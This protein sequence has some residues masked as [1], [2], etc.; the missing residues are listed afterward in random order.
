MTTKD[1]VFK[2][3]SL[4]IEAAFYGS[5]KVITKVQN[6][7]ALYKRGLFSL[8]IGTITVPLILLILGVV[9]D[10]RWIIAFAGLCWAGFVFALATVASPIAILIQATSSGLRGG[11][12]KYVKQVQRVLIVGLWMSLVLY[13]IPI[14]SN[15]AMVIPLILAGV[16]LA[17]ASPW[18]FQKRVIV[19]VTSIAMLFFI[20]SFFLPSTFQVLGMEALKF[21]R[22]P[23]SVEVT[24]ERVVNDQIE[25]FVDGKPMLWYHERDDGIYEWYD[26]E[27]N[28]PLFN[29]P[30]K[31]ASREI[32]QE[33]L[34]RLDEQ[35]QI[36]IQRQNREQIRLEEE[37]L[38]QEELE[39]QEIEE[40][41][42]H[43]LTMQ[44]QQI[45]MERERARIEQ[46]QKN[47]E[48]ELARQR[49][50]DARRQKENIA[51]QLEQAESDYY[52]ITEQAE[53]TYLSQKSEAEDVYRRKKQNSDTKYQRTKSEIEAAYKRK[54]NE[55]DSRYDRA[56][57]IA[58]TAYDQAREIAG[59]ND[60]LRD[61]ARNAR[62]EAI[63][64]ARDAEDRAQNEARLERD[65][66]LSSAKNLREQEE[67]RAR[68]EYE[69]TVNTAK[70]EYELAV[71]Q[72]KLEYEQAKRRYDN[73]RK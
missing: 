66:A 2:T 22:K 49:E 17:L 16:I 13:L 38:R 67:S 19:P 30:L 9:F 3:I 62:R 12:E 73:S 18:P 69:Q 31:P 64:R 48:A 11:A 26:R 21:D 23:R 39:Q 4:L 45:E 8:A 58:D 40:E 34:K 32:V 25:F 44:T 55:A 51:N 33:Q 14:R 42:Q 63:Q 65:R 37:R 71:Q 10:I 5:E 61:I 68:R 52:E 1:E 54:R 15:P 7:G 20:M 41:R 46:E 56:R 28:H 36:D 35:H 43:E 60:R 6:N 47:R 29:V 53:L 72:A 70:S 57:R 24:Y 50:L 27:G 59:R